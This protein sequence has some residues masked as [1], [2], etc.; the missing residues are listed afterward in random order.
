M[1]KDIYQDHHCKKASDNEQLL[2]F[3]CERIP[4]YAWVKMTVFSIS[5]P[6]VLRNCYTDECLL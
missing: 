6:G 4:D 3:I 1:E 2:K 5:N